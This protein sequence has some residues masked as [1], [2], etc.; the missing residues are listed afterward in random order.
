[1]PAATGWILVYMCLSASPHARC[2]AVHSCMCSIKFSDIFAGA[3]ETGESFV[4]MVETLFA[5]VST[6]PTTAQVIGAALKLFLKKPNP[7]PNPNP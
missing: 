7:N 1:M 5:E 3:K 4:G 2:P 6:M